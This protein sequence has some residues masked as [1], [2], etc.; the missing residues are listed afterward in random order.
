MI[1]DKVA[2][3]VRGILGMFPDS[4]AEFLFL[5][6]F[7]VAV[8]AGVVLVVHRLAPPLARLAAIALTWLITG[9]AGLV[10]LAEMTIAGGYRRRG[11][12]PPQIVYNVGDM[13]ASGTIGMIGGVRQVTGAAGAALSRAKVPVLVLLSAGWIWLWNY[14]HC[15]DG[16]PGC[17]RPVSVWYQQVSEKQ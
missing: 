6:V 7:V 10:L 11:A 16:A 3:L 8:M 17:D 13:I 15:P 4:A 5:P 2:G 14:Q 1:L 9:A 12:V